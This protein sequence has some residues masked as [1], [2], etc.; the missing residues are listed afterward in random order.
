MWVWQPATAAAHAD[1]A[2]DDDDNKFGGTSEYR[3]RQRMQTH[4]SASP[5]YVIIAVYFTIFAL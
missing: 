1:D 5:S 4:Q 2:D 3:T